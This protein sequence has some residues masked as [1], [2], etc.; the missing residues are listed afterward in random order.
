MTRPVDSNGARA[1]DYGSSYQERSMVVYKD[2]PPEPGTAAPNDTS[3]STT[4][5]ALA[6]QLAAAK[7]EI[8]RLNG[9][10]ARLREKVTDTAASRTEADPLTTF[11]VPENVIVSGFRALAYRIH[12]FVANYYKDESAK[13]FQAWAELNHSIMSAIHPDFIKMAVNKATSTWLVEA[14]IWHLLMTQV[15]SRFGPGEGRG[16]LWAGRYS[17]RLKLCKLSKTPTPLAV[18]GGTYYPVATPYQ[19]STDLS[20]LSPSLPPLVFDRSQQPR[21]AA[22]IPPLASVDHEPCHHG[23][24]AADGLP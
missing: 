17:T 20:P 23:G 5:V 16:M 11:R 4:D 8:R 9:I 3:A 7:D 24:F 2:L 1:G 21:K 12:N 22:G 6:D 13:D 10:N 14:V 19:H 15:F 18:L